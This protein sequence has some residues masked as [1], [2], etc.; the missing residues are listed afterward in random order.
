[1]PSYSSKPVIFVSYSHADEPDRPADGE[2]KWLSFVTAYLRPAERRGAVEIWSDR[3]MPGGEDWGPEIE[4]KLRTCAIFVLLVSH[5][6]MASDYVIDKEISLIRS[7][8]ANGEDVHFYP[9]LL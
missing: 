9:L 5:N 4:A 8:Q 6:S 2:V 1:M 3:L 7:R